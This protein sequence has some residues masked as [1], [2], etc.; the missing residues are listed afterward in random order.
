MCLLPA[1]DQ[2]VANPG[3]IRLVVW[4]RRVGVDEDGSVGV[5]TD[6]AHG[7]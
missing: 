7:Q 5:E 2:S 6:Q 3:V 1:V 4:S